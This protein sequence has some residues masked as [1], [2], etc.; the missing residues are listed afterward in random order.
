MAP[1]TLATTLRMSSSETQKHSLRKTF[2]QSSKVRPQSNAPRGQRLSHSTAPAFLG[3]ERLSEVPSCLH[4]QRPSGHLADRWTI[5]HQGAAEY[6][7]PQVVRPGFS[8]TLHKYP[9]S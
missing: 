7:M 4:P 1:G 8:R 9:S 6:F 2:L 3:G 5:P